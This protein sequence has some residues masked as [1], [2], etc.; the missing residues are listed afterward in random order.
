[1]LRIFLQ[2]RAADKGQMST[3]SL[4]AIKNQILA[5]NLIRGRKSHGLNKSVAQGFLKKILTPYGSLYKMNKVPLQPI[6]MV[7]PSQ[8]ASSRMSSTLLNENSARLNTEEE[9]IVVAPDRI[10]KLLQMEEMDEAELDAE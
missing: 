10:T 5:Q 8:P 9:E 3:T 6:K 7:V 2:A 4:N 1:M